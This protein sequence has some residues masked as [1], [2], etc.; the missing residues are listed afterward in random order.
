MGTDY[1]NFISW[2]REQRGFDGPV[3]DIAREFDREPQRISDIVSFWRLWRRLCE[4]ECER[5][6]V[7]ALFQARREYR[8]SLSNRSPQRKPRNRGARRHARDRG[9]PPTR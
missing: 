6:L 9:V 4:L 7:D 5:R 3:G 2:L 8:A 1:P